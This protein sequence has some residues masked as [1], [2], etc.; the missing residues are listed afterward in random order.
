MFII[1]T[2]L[3][4]K[5]ECILFNLTPNKLPAQIILNGSLLSLK[6]FNALISS[7]DSC[8]SYV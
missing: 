2:L 5:E 4:G 8:I 7:S 6:Y 3:T 1:F